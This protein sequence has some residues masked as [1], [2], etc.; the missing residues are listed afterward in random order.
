MSVAE[1]G[2]RE[3]VARAQGGD[4]E[5]FAVLYRRFHRAVH[6]T[7]LA[8]VR[9]GEANDVVQETFLV[10]WARLGELREPAAFGGW[11][12]A[13]ARSHALAVTRRRRREASGEVPDVGA[14][15]APRA[16]ALQVLALVQDLPEA[17]RATLLMRLL[18]EMTG[19]EIAEVTGLTPES[20]RVN[21]CRGMKLLREKLS[22]EG[23]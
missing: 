17:Y 22:V 4:R 18:E 20:V 12:L 3:L 21:L 13:I 1:P 10:G 19:P 15:A 5:A 7:A 16:E 14:A 6:A 2:V 23:A 8:V 11:L 9:Y